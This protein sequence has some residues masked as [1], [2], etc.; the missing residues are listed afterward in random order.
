M[1]GL[2]LLTSRAFPSSLASP[3]GIVTTFAIIASVVGADLSVEVIIVT[4]F[5]KLLG[6]GLAMGLGD[7]ISESAENTHTR[8]EFKREAWEYMNYP[9]G[10]VKEM[11]EIYVGK[12]FSRSD[13]ERAM[14]IMTR[15]PEYT[16]A[17]L[18]HMLVQELE[19]HLP[20]SDANPIKG[21][22][23]TFTSFMIFGS[24][25]IFFYCIFYGAGWTSKWGMFGVCIAVTLM[26]LFLLGVLQA[27]I[28]KQNAPLQGLY[29][30]INGSLA[31]AA[32]YGVGAGLQA[33]VGYH[34]C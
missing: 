6:D 18:K 3:T 23:V 4:G 31:A 26:L 19:A 14:A 5:A 7:A 27:V 21:G 22:A 16:D 12:G 8:T 17:F 13:A 9:E 28:I 15:K 10:E 30:M 34:G 1:D 11:V 24:I 29:M 25:P 2:T 33:A 32:A 20:D